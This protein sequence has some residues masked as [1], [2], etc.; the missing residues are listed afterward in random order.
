MKSLYLNL[1]SLF[2]VGMGFLFVILIGRNFGLGEQTDAYFITLTIVAYL[3]IIVSIAWASIKHFYAEFKVSNDFSVDRTLSLLNNNLLI[4]SILLIGGYFLLGRDLAFINA[5]TQKILDVMI[6]LVLIRSSISFQMNILNLGHIYWSIYAADGFVVCINIIV[7]LLVNPDDI[8]VVAY[9]T[10]FSSSVLLIVL[11][12]GVK[13]VTGFRYLPVFYDRKLNKLIF[14]SSFK[15]NASAL[16]YSIKDLM[17]VKVL[18]A[19]PEGTYST[20]SIANKFIGAVTAVVI[21]PIENIYT[22][23][24]SETLALKRYVDAGILVRKTLFRNSITLLLACSATYF[25]MPFIVPRAF[26]DSISVDDI[27]MLLMIFALLSGYHILRAVELPIKKVLNLFKFYDFGIFI[28]SIYI[29]VVGIGFLWASWE[30]ES[31]QL[32]FVFMIIAQLVKL[33][34]SSRRYVSTLSDKTGV[35]VKSGES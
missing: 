2:N 18:G 21:N 12:W 31:F 4:I 6:F 34:F 29:G 17:I 11:V 20:F 35:G 32:I 1:M 7:L 24:I 14:V 27:S 33:A 26:G 16:I 22:A 28:N 23:K 10:L 3:Q 30:A 9:T 25:L 8:L 15:L 5:T 19:A 13:R